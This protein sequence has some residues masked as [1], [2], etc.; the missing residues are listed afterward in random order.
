[1]TTFFKYIALFALFGLMACGGNS[2]DAVGPSESGNGAPNASGDS[3]TDQPINREPAAIFSTI[4]PQRESY[5]AA[6]PRMAFPR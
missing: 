4:F 5:R 3:Q 1:M 6:C 2:K